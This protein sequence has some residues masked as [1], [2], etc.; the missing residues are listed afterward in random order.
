[1]ITTS[2]TLTVQNVNDPPSWVDLPKNTTIN[3]TDIYNFTVKALDIDIGDNLTYGVEQSPLGLSINS[4]SGLMLWKPT[5]AQIGPHEFILKVTDGHV[6][7]KY[8][9]TI[10]VIPHPTEPP[11]IISSPNQTAVAG[12]EYRYGVQAK[13]NDSINLTFGLDISPY[14]MTINAST[15][16]VLWTPNSKQ[17]GYYNVS[18]NVSDGPH[19]IKQKF[20][21]QVLAEPNTP[22]QLLSYPPILNY[23]AGDKFEYKVKASDPDIGDI[24]TFELIVKPNGM[25]INQSSGG[26]SWTPI[27][28]DVG[29]HDI[30]VLISDDKGGTA[31]LNFTLEVSK[32]HQP[33]EDKP[34]LVPML[35]ILS[36]LC[37]IVAAVVV[38]FA[39]KRKQK[40]NL[41]NDNEPDEETSDLTEDKEESEDEPDIS[42]SD[43]DEISNEIPLLAPVAAVKKVKPLPVVDDIFL[44]YNDGRIIC[45]FTRIDKPQPDKDA[46]K[47]K[48]KTVQNLIKTS[49]GNDEIMDEISFGKN[50]M[51]IEHGNYIYI[52]SVVKHRGSNE[53]HERMKI[54]VHNIEIELRAQLKVWSGDKSALGGAKAWLNILLSREPMERLPEPAPDPRLKLDQYHVETEHKP[55][56]GEIEMSGKKR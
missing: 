15:G 43:Y 19:N 34:N 3:D 31:Y 37:I 9:F 21:V 44:L 54:A 46:L 40:E 56:D 45:H 2:F 13:D 47:N 42:S 48:L 11:Y 52:L 5:V 26:I 7:L 4:K 23:S 17:I 8:N 10:I 12:Q 49:S 25:T 16:L 14:G 53:L 55:R 28:S 38:Y 36:V 39:V 27:A 29:T 51:L 41:D 30:H 35:L 33:V 6:V 18:I 20:Q 22:P 1:M 32:K 24:L 50:K